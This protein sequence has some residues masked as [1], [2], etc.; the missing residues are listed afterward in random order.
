MSGNC[1]IF[2][3]QHG[4][5]SYNSTMI[6]EITFWTDDK[7]WRGILSDLGAVFAPRDTAD[8]IWC[9]PHPAF[10]K[11]YGGLRRGAPPLRGGHIKAEI[12]RLRDLRESQILKKVCGNTSVSE[13]QKKLI[14]ALYRA[15]ENGASADELQQQLGYAIG[16]KT[17]AANTAIYQLRKIFGKEFIRNEG[18]RYKL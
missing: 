5:L 9:P 4:F 11:G 7:V 15:G 6:N 2:V 1:R 14:I 8:V 3:C 16:A 17:N 18:G 12:L 10:A 13:A